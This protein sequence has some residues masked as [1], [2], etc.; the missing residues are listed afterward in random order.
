MAAILWKNGFPVTCIA[1]PDSVEQLNKTGI[2]LSSK[3]FGE[4]S[5]H[6]RV[7]SILEEDPD[8]LFIATKANDLPGALQSVMADF[9]K[10][11][12]IIPLLN[13]VEHLEFLRSHFGNRVA[14][15]MIGKTESKSESLGRIIH[16]SPSPPVIEL[17]AERIDRKTIEKIAKILKDA[18]IEVNILN[19]DAEVI[20]RK[21]V[22][23]NAIAC[24]TAATNQPL[25]YARN[26]PEWNKRLE[27]CVSEGVLVAKAE[28]VFLDPEL[29]MKEINSFPAELTTSLQRDINAGQLSELDA[30][31]GAILRRAK[32][33][34]IQC[35]A[36]EDIFHTLLKLEK[37]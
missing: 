23:L 31:P 32:R 29:L 7:V 37:R 10:K 2:R 16:S 18:G 30:I 24:V 28:G 12:V 22:R 25:G 26:N 1:R 27:N 13:G 17:S 11:A 14:A 20:W 35:P 4:I 15:G 36:I 9:L 3:I 34:G 8:F 5:A 19:K 6:P 21:L 33:H